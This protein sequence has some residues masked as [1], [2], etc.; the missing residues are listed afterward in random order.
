MKDLHADEVPAADT[1]I[2]IAPLDLT[3]DPFGRLVLTAGGV[4][5]KGVVPVRAFPIGA[6]DEGI[7]LVGADGHELAWVDRLDQLPEP[8]RSLVAEELASRD[9][10]PE[11]H[12]IAAVSGYVTPCTWSVETDRGPARFILKSEESIRRLSPTRF[13]IADSRGINF[14]VSDL[15]ELD[16]VSRK[17]LDRFL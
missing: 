11:I 16:V 4:C 12:R 8:Q 2:P 3:R 17:V 5:H 10:T 1:I 9:F 13:L 7:G 15:R 6:P 14:L